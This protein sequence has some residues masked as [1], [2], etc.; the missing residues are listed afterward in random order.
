MYVIVVIIVFL[1][2][3]IKKVFTSC[4]CDYAVAI[5]FSFYTSY[6]LWIISLNICAKSQMLVIVHFS[7]FIKDF[8]M[9]QAQ[10][11]YPVMCELMVVLIT[12]I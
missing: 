1:S 3:C 2:L 4:V 8:L 6:V 5:T 7:V 12:D 11:W 10:F 9:L